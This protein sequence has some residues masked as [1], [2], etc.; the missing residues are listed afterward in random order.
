MNE[1]FPASQEAS[2]SS[3]RQSKRPRSNPPAAQFDPSQLPPTER[4]SKLDKTKA[5]MD[6][7]VAQNK[8]GLGDFLE[9]LLDPETYDELSK[10]SR[11]SLSNWLLGSTRVG[12][13]PA[14]IVDAIY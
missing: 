6:W 5:L 14:E 9:T 2:A 12:T 8:Y 10:S 7:L 11:Q 4:L 3:S 13:R 1:P